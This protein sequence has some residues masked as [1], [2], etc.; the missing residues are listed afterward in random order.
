MQIPEETKNRAITAILST[1]ADWELAND[2]AGSPPSG[3]LVRAEDLQAL[4][5]VAVRACGLEK[6]IAVFRLDELARLEVVTANRRELSPVGV[7]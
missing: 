3:L 5:T 6:G 7:N 1:V 2:L 4:L